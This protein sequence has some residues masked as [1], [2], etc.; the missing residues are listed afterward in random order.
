VPKNAQIIYEDLTN[1]KEL[2]VATPD[3]V[4]GNYK[5]VLPYGKNYGIT[6][7]IDGYI[8]TSENIDLSKI[9]GKYLEIEGK[10]MTVIPSKDVEVGTKIEMKNIFFQFGKAALQ[11]ESYYELNRLASFF[12]ENTK[13]ITEIGGHTDNLGTDLVNNKLSQER[14]DVVR[15]Y[16]LTQGVPAE[17]ITSKG[18]GKYDPKVSNDTPENQAINRRVEFKVLK[19]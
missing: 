1:G 2:G 10:D 15:N 3:P 16:L 12:K 4:T 6:T 8:S 11:P 17:R 18:Y 19:N 5:V 9:T 14:A 13:M 7:K